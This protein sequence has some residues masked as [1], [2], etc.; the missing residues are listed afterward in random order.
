MK[1][2]RM[3][4]AHLGLAGAQDDTETHPQA[5]RFGRMLGRCWLVTHLACLAG[6]GACLWQAAPTVLLTGWSSFVL[7][8]VLLREV[9]LAMPARLD[10]PRDHRH[11]DLALAAVLGLAWGLGIALL[12]PYADAA[13]IATLLSG[14]LAVAL[15]AVPV[16]GDEPGAYAYFLG[17]TGLVA[18]GGLVHDGRY[19][20]LVLWVALA[21]ATLALLNN[22]YRN[23]HRALRVLLL[24][25]RHLI[26]PAGL[27]VDYEHGSLFESAERGLEALRGQ[28]SRETRQ[29]QVLGELGDALVT[30]DASGNIDYL[31]GAATALLGV[32]TATLDGQALEDSVR[33]VYGREP[34]NRTRDIF[35]QARRSGKP[36]ALND[37]A[38]LLRRDG[39]A[40]GVDYLFTPLAD[41][42]GEFDGVSLQLRDVTTRRQ[43]TESIA[44]RASH[45]ALTGTI[46]RAEFE[47][48][49]HKLLSRRGDSQHNSHTLL[50]IDI[51]KFKFINDTYGHAAGDHALRTLTEVLRTRIRGA[52]T[53]ARIGGDEFCALLYSCDADR[54]RLIGEGLRSAIEQHDFHWQAIQLPVS[55]SVGLVEISADMRNTAD[56]LRAADAA[57]YSAKNFGR[58]RVQMFEAVNGEGAQQE[59]RLS[60]V[61]EIQ[62][63]LAAG[64][65][66]LF[67]Q[68]LCA[69]TASLPIDRCEV[70][71]GIRNGSDDYI[72]RHEVAEVAARYQLSA[73]I[74]RWLIKASLE[75]LRGDHP[76]LS[77]MRALLI[78]LSAQSIGDDRLLEYA[79]RMVREN[80]EVAGRIGFSLPESGIAQHLEF[81][82]YFITTLKQDGCQFMIGD[83]GFGGA[84]IE[85][86]KSLQ[87]DYLGIRGSFVRNLLASSADYEVV[88]GLCRVAQALGMQ[89]VA[90]HADSRSL[91][92]AL[93]K[94][95][96]DFAKGLLHDGPRRVA[97]FDESLL[98]KRGERLV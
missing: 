96:V 58:N 95:G 54:A 85:A 13:T 90:E 8:N 26:R 5:L 43:R 39:I 46:N 40:V 2:G 36:Q 94:M 72:P 97:R 60:Q 24:Q 84:G 28:V 98:A 70:T 27:D 22:L 17:S 75:A 44:W 42:A 89:T 11:L 74:D 14:A 55:I 88:L 82:R 87:L 1:N 86:L 71:V 4:L 16:F 69:T 49:M 19:A 91:R 18:I 34:H 59:R 23:T 9:L 76:V 41:A 57:C 66:D 10:T 31:N 78:P 50:Y 52:D 73:D 47:R 20:N 68:P 61:R 81:V 7:L 67:Y 65:L 6:I 30:T 48:R 83:L 32:D 62:S 53:L 25:L 35:E 45:D 64:H 33:L 92:D 15:V 93:A 29:A 37:Q 63:A 3:S 38:Q 77:D 80:T 79:I 12:M 51:D 21:M 56:L